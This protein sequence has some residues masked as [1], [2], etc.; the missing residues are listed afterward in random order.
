MAQYDMLSCTDPNDAS[1]A[2]MSLY[3]ISYRTAQQNPNIGQYLEAE[4][5]QN[6]ISQ[7]GGGFAGGDP[8]GPVKNTNRYGV[9]K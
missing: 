2:S 9:Q 3:D 4:M 6:T 8:H 7:Y 1:M 5:S